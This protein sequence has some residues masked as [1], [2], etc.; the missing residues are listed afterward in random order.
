M[1]DEIPATKVIKQDAAVRHWRIV[2]VIVAVTVTMT[3]MT[4]MTVMER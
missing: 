1:K 3:V 4:G 2:M